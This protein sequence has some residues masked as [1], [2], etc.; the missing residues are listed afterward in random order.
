LIRLP[1]HRPLSIP[2]SVSPAD[3]ATVAAQFQPVIRYISRDI[4][5]TVVT[6]A[7]QK[8]GGVPMTFFSL[9]LLAAVILSLVSIFPTARTA[10]ADTGDNQ[11]SLSEKD[12]RAIA[13][14]IDKLMKE[15]Q[16]LYDSGRFEESLS[17]IREAKKYI[18]ISGCRPAEKFYDLS[19]RV[20][21][22][23]LPGLLENVKRYIRQGKGFDAKNEYD[24]YRYR[25]DFINQYA[26]ANETLIITDEIR[27]L[28]PKIYLIIVHWA[29]S[30]HAEY[31]NTYPVFSECYLDI[32]KKY[33]EYLKKFG[34]DLD[35]DFDVRY[36]AVYGF[37]L[38]DCYRRARIYMEKLRKGKD[39]EQNLIMAEVMLGIGSQS[40]R[41]GTYS[42]YLNKELTEE[43]Y[44]LRKELDRFK[45]AHGIPVI[46]LKP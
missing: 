15:A 36:E 18:I 4:L 13:N 32:A 29:L 12:L 11:G 33:N 45:A 26:D 7:W 38:N 40:G 17:V 23:T 27:G 42:R 22:A 10:F 5:K 9:S 44:E 3:S 8:Q 24:A 2:I 25:V 20:M 34:Q 30:R 19:I 16:A 1:A 46:P 21:R 37:D 41:I 35:I 43:Y 14:E 39:V 6:S 31:M 28:E